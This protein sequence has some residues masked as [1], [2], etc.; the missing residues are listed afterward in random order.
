MRIATCREM[1]KRSWPLAPWCWPVPSPPGP[2][3]LQ[4]SAWACQTAHRIL[5]LWGKT[6][7]WWSPED[8]KLLASDTL[9]PWQRGTRP[10]AQAHALLRVLHCWLCWRGGCGLHRATGILVQRLW[11]RGVEGPAVGQEMEEA[12]GGSHDRSQ[13]AWD[14][15][16]H[17]NVAT[18]PTGCAWPCSPGR[19]RE[20]GVGAQRVPACQPVLS[21]VGTDSLY[22]EKSV[23]GVKKQENFL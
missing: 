16:S 8:G 10:A 15:S 17:Q 18:T 20:L 7:R 6:Q 12:K 9:G 11:W 14:P 3:G 19:T 5:H 2:P 23:T 4:C 13:D 21:A 22:C 1:L